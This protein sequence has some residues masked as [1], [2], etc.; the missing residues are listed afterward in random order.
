MSN[1]EIKDNQLKIAINLL[2]D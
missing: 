2:V 1:L